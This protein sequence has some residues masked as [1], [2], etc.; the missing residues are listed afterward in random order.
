[1]ELSVVIPAYNEEHTLE[2]TIQEL[3][4]ALKAANLDFEI[5][6]V[7]D[8][9]KDGTESKLIEL[10]RIHPDL[11]HILNEG[12]HGYGHAVRC[13]L[14]H[15]R[16]EAVAIVMA[17]GSDSPSDLV[18]YAMK[19]REGH[20]CAFGSRFIPGARV[21]DYPRFKLVLNRLGNWLIAWLFGQRYYDLTNGFKCYGRQ[22]IDGMQPLVSGQFNLTM[23]MSLKAVSSR[24]RYAVVPTSWRNRDAGTSKFKVLAQVYL[25]LLTLLY[26]LV[27]TKVVPVLDRSA[28]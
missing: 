21:D 16:G 26:C 15:Y 27:I 17:D 25:Y 24:A 22:V 23:E 12:K 19:M 10:E 9:S 8:G 1:M 13:G 5:L 7:N 3:A 4:E 28:R 14:A 6:V 20:Q 2:R 18:A 11:R